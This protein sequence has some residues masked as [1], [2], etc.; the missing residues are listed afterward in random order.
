MQSCLWGGSEH[1][2]GMGAMSEGPKAGESRSPLTIEFRDVRFSVPANKN[3]RKAQTYILKGLAGTC[4]G[5]R[6][7]AI[8]GASGAG[9]QV[10][11]GQSHISQV[12]LVHWTLRLKR[13]V[14]SGLCANDPLT[15]LQPLLRREDNLGEFIALTQDPDQ[16]TGSRSPERNCTQHFHRGCQLCTDAAALAVRS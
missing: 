7:T 16:Q 13:G 15:I 14:L 6:L 3:S 4:F 11:L 2:P 10:V 12:L 1:M 8:M 9:E 5:A